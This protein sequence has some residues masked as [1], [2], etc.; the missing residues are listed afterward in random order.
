MARKSRRRRKWRKYF[1]GT[2]DAKLELGATLANATAISAFFPDTVREK[3]WITSIDAVWS[4]HDFTEAAEDGPIL[5]GIAHG[6]YST[7]EI[8]AWVENLGSWDE[9]DLVQQEV[10][11]RKIRKVGIF[12]TGDAV[13]HI[14]LNDGKPI[15][16]KCGWMLVTGETLR[17]WGY[18][19]GTS[20]LSGGT[21]P[22]VRCAGVA[23]LWPT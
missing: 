8:E 2:V 19:M 5:V 23:H 7:A 6:D 9:G 12:P 10:A 11:K 4:L 21:T 22:T 17:L 15:H 3:A 20:N 13:D 14:V 16:T 1:A 18:N